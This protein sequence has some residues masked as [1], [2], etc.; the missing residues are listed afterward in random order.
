MRQNIKKFASIIS[1][2]LPI[3]EPIYEFG[4]LQVPGQKGF[5]DLRPIFSNKEYIG[6]DMIEGQGVDKILDLHAIDL[7][8]ESIGLV[9]CFDTL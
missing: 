6:C 5:S 9:L 3:F 1:T 4:S 8:S 7:P 2:T